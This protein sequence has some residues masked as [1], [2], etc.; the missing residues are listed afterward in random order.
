MGTRSDPTS[1][2]LMEW[3]RKN[4]EPEVLVHLESLLGGRTVTDKTFSEALVRAEA[5]RELQGHK[6]FTF[7]ALRCN[8]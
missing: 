1:E 7:G 2:Q 8:S 4:I 3:A 5:L 6:L